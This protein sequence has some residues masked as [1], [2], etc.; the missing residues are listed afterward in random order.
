ML[1]PGRVRLGWLG[2]QENNPSNP[3]CMG[4]M[5]NEKM[6]ATMHR[7]KKFCAY[8]KP[9]ERLAR[10][11]LNMEA[12]LLPEMLE[13]STYIEISDTY[14]NYCEAVGME[15]PSEDREF[16]F[17]TEQCESEQ[18]MRHWV[19]QFK[20]MVTRDGIGMKQCKDDTCMFMKHDQDGKLTLWAVLLCDDV[21]Y[22]GVKSAT[23]SLKRLVTSH[24][25][26]VEIGKLDV[27]SGV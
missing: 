16:K 12:G 1:S 3:E 10:E 17:K 20:Y 21:I 6:A 24:V 27:H 8:D 9:I 5:P 13:E 19:K 2:I 15:P 22:G 23:D 7:K 18:E 14:R 11:D 26:I 4:H 25:T